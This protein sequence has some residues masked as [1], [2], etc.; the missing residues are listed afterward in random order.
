ML[1]VKGLSYAFCI[2]IVLRVFCGESACSW[3]NELLIEEAARL[4]CQRKTLPKDGNL[5]SLT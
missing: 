2:K 3:Q 5:M 4:L 1:Q